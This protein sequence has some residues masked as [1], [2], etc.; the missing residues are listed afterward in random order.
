MTLMSCYFSPT[1]EKDFYAG[2]FDPALPQHTKRFPLLPSVL[3]PSV[4]RQ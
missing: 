4:L 3:L 2:H 1:R